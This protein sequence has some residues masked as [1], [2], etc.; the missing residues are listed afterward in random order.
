MRP[1]EMTAN[2]SR[3]LKTSLGSLRSLSLK[4][5]TGFL[6]PPAMVQDSVGTDYGQDCDGERLSGSIEGRAWSTYK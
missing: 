3:Q 2:H 5:L 6:T 1:K 4:M